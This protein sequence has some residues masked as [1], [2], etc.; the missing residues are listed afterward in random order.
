MIVYSGGL[1]SSGKK[2]ETSTHTEKLYMSEQMSQYCR[3]E[4]ISFHQCPAIQ[5]MTNMWK[6]WIRLMLKKIVF[7][8]QLPLFCTFREVAAPRNIP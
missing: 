1:R 7:T 2:N 3:W 8:K 5:T 4:K 6:A